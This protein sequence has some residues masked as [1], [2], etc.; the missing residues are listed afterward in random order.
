MSPPPIDLS[1]VPVP[2][3]GKMSVAVDFGQL[4]LFLESCPPLMIAPT[5]TTFS[6]VVS[7]NI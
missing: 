6:G 4:P 7:V 3:E 1:N 5:G 2:D